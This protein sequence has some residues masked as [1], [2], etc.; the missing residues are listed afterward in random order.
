MHSF[1]DQTKEKNAGKEERGKTGILSHKQH[2]SS[3]FALSSRLDNTCPSSPISRRHSTST[4]HP[5]VILHHTFF[6]AFYLLLLPNET[7]GSHGT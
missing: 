2:C 1:T 7:T 5:R 3:P 6:N 4:T